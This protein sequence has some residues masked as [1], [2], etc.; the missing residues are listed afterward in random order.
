[1]KICLGYKKRQ[2]ASTGVKVSRAR[3]VLYFFIIVSRRN[4]VESLRALWLFLRKEERTGM[5]SD[6]MQRR[7]MRRK[8]DALEQTTP[9]VDY[10]SDEPQSAPCRR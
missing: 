1:M 4:N 7:S 2:S 10:P 5:L 9:A 3:L 8:E 6:K